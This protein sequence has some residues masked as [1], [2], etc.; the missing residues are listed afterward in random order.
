[1]IK[2]L[3]NKTIYIQF[4]SNST[5]EPQKCENALAASALVKI[6]QTSKYIKNLVLPD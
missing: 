2:T 6:L 4:I 3:F 1:M 5:I